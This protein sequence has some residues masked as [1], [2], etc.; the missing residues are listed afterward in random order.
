MIYTL[1][2]FTRNLACIITCSLLCSL[3]TNADDNLQNQLDPYF[4]DTTQLFNVLGD[5][6]VFSD[7]WAD[8]SE[9]L[10]D[11]DLEIALK[12]MQFITDGADDLEDI[13]LTAFNN[14]IS[15][16][17]TT[18][19]D[20]YDIITGNNIIVDPVPGGL[21]DFGP[22]PGAHPSQPLTIPEPATVV[23]CLLGI[24][25]VRQRSRRNYKA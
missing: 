5:E 6:I 9:I 15:Q 19:D 17:Q 8:V 3:S 10:T 2:H 13:D 23:L 16:L 24:G 4:Q 20:L 12:D 25:L 14:F 1:K 18:H 21:P 22:V 11:Y 7:V